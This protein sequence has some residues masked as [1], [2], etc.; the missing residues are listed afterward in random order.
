VADAVCLQPVPFEPHESMIHPPAFTDTG[1]QI[2]AAYCI[3]SPST[4]GTLAVHLEGAVLKDTRFRTVRS[5]S[6]PALV[7]AT[8]STWLTRAPMCASR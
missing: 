8:R 6:C 4:D 5:R 3:D 2:E 7:M 1:A